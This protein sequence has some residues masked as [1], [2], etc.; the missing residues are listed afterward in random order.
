MKK[1]E[2]GN[3]NCTSNLRDSDMNTCERFN[4]LM[5]FEPVD[6]TLNWE[7]AYWVNV[8]RKWYTEGLPESEGV[9][10]SLTGSQILHGPALFWPDGTSLGGLDSYPIA[11]DVNGYF[12]FDKEIIRVPLNL[13]VDPPFETE[14]IEENE[15]TTLMR[16]HWGVKELV[17][18]DASCAPAYIEWPVKNRA[19]WEKLKDERFQPGIETRVP[20]D[21]PQLIKKFE[22]EITRW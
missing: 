2:G 12:N 13:W 20:L 9:P 3:P 15:R 10:E 22:K 5:A 19:D 11:K 1:M 7:F 17:K 8:V 6:R 18:N 21:Y 16:E 14:I 4:A